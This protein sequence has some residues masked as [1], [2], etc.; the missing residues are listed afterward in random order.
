MEPMKVE[1][2][3]TKA[4]A[5]MKVEINDTKAP[6]MTK[7]LSSYMYGCCNSRPDVHESCDQSWTTATS[8]K[9]AQRGAPCTQDN[10]R[11]AAEPEDNFRRAAEAEDKFRRAPSAEQIS[12][13][14]PKQRICRGTVAS[15]TQ[16]CCRQLCS[17]DRPPK[18]SNREINE[19]RAGWERI[20]VQVDSGA[21]DTVAPKD[22]AK[23]FALRE[24]PAS[25]RGVGFVAANGSKI[26]NYG[27]RKVTG[28]TDEG[29]AISMR[30]TCADVHKVLGSVHKMNQGGNLVVLDG[31]YS[32]MKNKA[33]GQRT[34]IHYED[35]QYIMYMWVPCGPNEVEKSTKPLGENRFAI[36]A[37]EDEQGFTRQVRSE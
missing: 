33:S 22:V 10:F 31:K 29:T 26:K 25:R 28:Y 18:G 2:N 4:P 14:A 15:C 19:V 27:E 24:T 11:R 21:I 13:V 9:R 12:G 6:A 7:R 3:G 20:R 5:P 30:M 35:G 1:I 37:A 32:Y 17:I 16:G 34:K 8:K 36:L 23:K